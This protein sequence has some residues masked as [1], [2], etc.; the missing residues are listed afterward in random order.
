MEEKDFDRLKQMVTH[1]VDS[2]LERQRETTNEDFK[3]HIGI[4][5]EDFQHKLQIVAE[6]HQMLSEK[7]DRVEENLE[8]KIDAVAVDL[9]AHRID[10]EGHKKG[11]M[12]SEP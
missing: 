8:K 11:Y 4:L 9:A 6:G 7:L 5:T 12:V 1:I 3:H 2:K 10:T